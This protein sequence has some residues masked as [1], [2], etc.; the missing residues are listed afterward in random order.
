MSQPYYRP[1]QV[2]AHP[3][4]ANVDYARSFAKNAPS[5]AV[6]LNCGIGSRL[7]NA[8]VNAF[9][10]LHRRPCVKNVRRWENHR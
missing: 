10:R 5:F 7:L 9:E 4:R 1:V 3:E 8:L 2:M 6:A